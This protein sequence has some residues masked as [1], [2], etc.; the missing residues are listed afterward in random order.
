MTLSDYI[1][2]SPR[3][4]TPGSTAIADS[5]VA[6]NSE[7][8]PS[9]LFSNVNTLKAC[10]HGDPP[11][12]NKLSKIENQ[13][14]SETHVTA[15][16]SSHQQ[17]EKILWQGN[18]GGQTAD[19]EPISA[20][21]QTHITC[22]MECRED[23]MEENDIISGDAADI[24]RS[25]MITSSQQGSF[26]FS[27]VQG[28]P[29]LDSQDSSLP[30]LIETVQRPTFCPDSG[31][32]S[33]SRIFLAQSRRKGT[34]CDAPSATLNQSLSSHNYNN[35]KLRN[36]GLPESTTFSNH[37]L[38]HDHQHS[39]MLPS[40]IVKSANT[41]F[42]NG[43][44]TLSSRSHIRSPNLAPPHSPEA[45]YAADTVPRSESDTVCLLVMS[46]L[47]KNKIAP[48]R[49][50]NPHPDII[51]NRLELQV[52]EDGKDGAYH[53][54]VSG[55]GSAKYQ[56]S[57]LCD[58]SKP[59]L[60]LL[61]SVNSIHFEKNIFSPKLE[62][63]DNNVRFGR[64]PAMQ[65]MLN[66]NHASAREVDNIV[67]EGSSNLPLETVERQ[68]FPLVDSLLSI[69]SA[70][71][72]KRLEH[73]SA[74]VD[75]ATNEETLA[76]LPLPVTI[77][78][79]PPCQQQ[80]ISMSMAHFTPATSSGL[81]I[82]LCP[83]GA[84][85]S[86][87]DHDSGENEK[88]ESVQSESTMRRQSKRALPR[89][90][91]TLDIEAQN[92]FLT[93]DDISDRA[94]FRD[95]SNSSAGAESISPVDYSM[96]CARELQKGG[97]IGFRSGLDTAKDIS[98]AV[99][100]MPMDP[101]AVTSAISTQA[102]FNIAANTHQYPSGHHQTDYA[103]PLAHVAT[104][105]NPLFLSSNKNSKV[106][107]LTEERLAAAGAGRKQ[108]E[109]LSS[110]E[111]RCADILASPP[112]PEV[113]SRCSRS[114][115][116]DR[117][118]PL[119][120]KFL[121]RQGSSSFPS[122][123]PQANSSTAHRAI[124]RDEQN[125]S[126]DSGSISR[127][128]PACPNEGPLSSNATDATTT[129]ST[130]V[131]PNDPLV[132]NPVNLCSQPR[133]S[134]AV[135]TTRTLALA[136]MSLPMPSHPSSGVV[137][138]DFPSPAPKV[139]NSVIIASTTTASVPKSSSAN[140]DVSMPLMAKKVIAA[141]TPLSCSIAQAG[142]SPPSIV[143]K[144]CTAK[145]GPSELYSPVLIPKDNALTSL[146][147]PQH[148]FGGIVHSC[149]H[150]HGDRTPA[151][152]S[153]NSMAVLST[154][155]TLPPAKGIML[156]SEKPS[157]D[158]KNPKLSPST[159]AS[160]VP[161]RRSAD[162]DHARVRSTP[163]AKR[164]LSKMDN[165]ASSAK[166]SR[167]AVEETPSPLPRVVSKYTKSRSAPSPAVAAKIAAIYSFVE[168][169][170]CNR[171]GRRSS[172]RRGTLRNEVFNGDVGTLIACAAEESPQ[173]FVTDE[174]KT[175]SS[176]PVPSSHSNP[177]TR[178]R[179]SSYFARTQDPNT[180]EMDSGLPSRS[181][182][183]SASRVSA[184][185]RRARPTR[186]LCGPCDAIEDEGTGLPSPSLVGLRKE[187]SVGNAPVYS[188]SAGA[189]GEVW[190]DFAVSL[191]RDD[192]IKIPPNT[193]NY[194][195]K[196]EDGGEG[197]FHFS[198]DLKTSTKKMAVK[199]HNH[200]KGLYVEQAHHICEQGKEDQLGKGVAHVELSETGGAYRGIANRMAVA[201]EDDGCGE[202]F[203]VPPMEAKPVIRYP[204]SVVRAPR[205]YRRRDLR[206]ENVSDRCSRE[207]ASAPR[208]QR[209]SLST[210]LIEKK[211]KPKT[212]ASRAPKAVVRDPYEF[213]SDDHPPPQR[214]ARKC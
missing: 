101:A 127:R 37:L 188:Y 134:S 207:N 31:L 179:H 162:P 181:P 9:V 95:L 50:L 113:P 143:A 13:R 68:M 149:L 180:P 121:Y 107:L 99:N 65:S 16:G 137:L 73:P 211:R 2:K 110:P 93:H 90:H 160:N 47:Q 58:Q 173:L 176:K 214:P 194:W 125:L 56:G 79:D 195:K 174:N 27:Y 168:E 57:A 43:L 183:F 175:G 91:H 69:T 7:T 150:E 170:Q 66:T 156:A 177:H 10:A 202:Q 115:S 135:Q 116:F 184:F 23:R 161:L 6:L 1:C 15:L 141:G 102:P 78:S 206:D 103:T 138:F 105:Q 132:S 77:N 92:N 41:S 59:S 136:S 108:T 193:G 11:P 182:S 119:R 130:A 209:C 109:S 85:S 12:E 83:L 100:Y 67:V 30:P 98:N 64:I 205:Q 153:S 158:S 166:K 52:D 120:L 144:T 152:D 80:D 169:D 157:S 210:D 171:N 21:A 167:E 70:K 164:C 139:V 190:D 201:V 106:M 122:H 25:K 5:N 76:P 129:I 112:S 111:K 36:D 124:A 3:S 154:G 61:P 55:A 88:K 84:E 94:H 148:D 34:T 4:P 200:D 62:V 155:S 38:G 159:V 86:L 72:E 45:P 163:R 40:N 8:V 145:E 63:T 196:D 46:P 44:Y 151:Q 71:L 128:Y 18:D 33:K 74:N 104:S 22:T 191:Q 147:T 126:F 26:A 192:G 49:C 87:V 60:P 165:Q 133:I 89:K 199:L 51:H 118:S 32:V 29:L 189:S 24:V 81:H 198:S 14:D 185:Q 140:D 97:C 142:R 114:P 187:S 39:S 131:F 19:I 42:S 186:S 197:S 117:P 172:S 54:D 75:F 82:S 213:S 96:P 212:G 208:S 20:P 204:A 203:C 28:D 35:S 123:T 53:R 48:I 146:L 178:S 17:E